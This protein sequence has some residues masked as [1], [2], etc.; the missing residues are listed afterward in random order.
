MNGFAVGVRHVHCTDVD[1][2]LRMSSPCFP[3]RCDC[4]GASTAPG[5]EEV[6]YCR[7]YHRYLKESG[8]YPDRSL[9]TVS[10]TVFLLQKKCSEFVDR[11]FQ[12]WIITNPI[13]GRYDGRLPAA[14]IEGCAWMNPGSE[15]VLPSSF[16]P[17]E[18]EAARAAVRDAAEKNIKG[19]GKPIPGTS[20]SEMSTVEETVAALA[21]CT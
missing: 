17:P 10:R 19:Y 5:S 20:K 7:T 2:S 18:L 16:T 14:A 3:G 6:P 15:L 13:L 8:N 9:I 11:V 1:V 4:S 21:V 12:E